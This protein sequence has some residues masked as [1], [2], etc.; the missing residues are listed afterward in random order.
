MV[1]Q[2]GKMS[3]K[4]LC[5]LQAGRLISLVLLFCCLTG[6][7]LLLA[8]CNLPAFSAASGM[9]PFED[10]LVENY[11]P[12]TD[13]ASLPRQPL[14]P[15]QE[16]VLAVYGYPGRF[17][18][19]FSQDEAGTPIRQETWY[20][21]A[22]GY[23]V[24]FRDGMT[25]SE[26]S[27]ATAAPGLSPYTPELFTARMDIDQLLAV[28][29]QTS[30][31]I[32]SANQSGLEEGKQVS[33]TGLTAGFERGELRFL[34][35]I[36]VEG[37]AQPAASTAASGYT[38]T[39]L[40]LPHSGSNTLTVTVN[41]PDGSS[42]QTP[43]TIQMNFDDS[44]L[45]YQ[46]TVSGMSLRLKRLAPNQYTAAL[47]G[48]E[49]ATLTFSE[50]GWRLQMGSIYTMQSG[51][52]AEQTAPSPAA[53]M[54]RIFLQSQRDGNWELYSMNEDGSQVVRL[55]NDPGEDNLLGCSPDGQWIAFSSEREGKTDMYRMDL[56]GGNVQKL[57][58]IEIDYFANAQWLDNQTIQY[59]HLLTMT[60]YRLDLAT[61]QIAEIDE[62]TAASAPPPNSVA[63][64]GAVLSITFEYDGEQ[65]DTEILLTENGQETK[66]TNDQGIRQ[67]SPVWSPDGQRIVFSSQEDGDMELYIMDRSGQILQK[68]T[69]N[70]VPDTAVCWLK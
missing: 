24:T 42:Y 35:A 43:L 6:L 17:T 25:V 41:N 70:T 11:Q 34:E 64:Q 12:Q 46:D 5:T 22:N 44:G 59:I 1:N 47:D 36:P 48:G 65:T 18:I 45:T 49:T 19:L 21:D 55:T 39:D 28:T 9:D 57:T 51:L 66:L 52:A 69:D 8:A 38:L 37:L 58:D 62:A 20:F 63:F 13:P 4:R 15:E 23:A 30:F 67:F 31:R 54:G 14:S 26:T 32:Q 29:G 53:S 50:S 10:G 61:N 2:G 40:E 68:L 3:I 16:E 56:T 33:L 7:S 27:E 60:Y